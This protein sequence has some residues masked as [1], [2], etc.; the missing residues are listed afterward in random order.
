MPTAN[1]ASIAT[2]AVVAVCALI[3]VGPAVWGFIDGVVVFPWE[4]NTTTTIIVPP[5]GQVDLFMNLNHFVDGGAPAATTVWLYDAN[6]NFFSSAASSTNLVTFTQ[7]ATPGAHLWYQIRAAAPNAAAYATYTSPLREVIV[8]EGDVNGDAFLTLAPVMIHET[9]TSAATFTITDQIGQSINAEATQYVNA[10]D[11][12]LFVN[13]GVTSDCSWGTPEDFI[14]ARTGRHYLW[15]GWVV[16]SCTTSQ[17]ITNADF[18]FSTPTLYY[19]G[20]RLPT[21]TNFASTGYNTHILAIMAPSGF[22]ASADFD[23]D[24]YDTMW[25]SSLTGVTLG[26]FLNGDSDLNPT[27]LANKVV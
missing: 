13:I 27:A 25:A 5:G 8:P 16:L 19:Y 4:K 12:S 14:D 10:T 22:T 23:F 2:L 18:A 9:S 11:T 20:F 6:M 17:G 15:G 1:K 7:K 26:S 24:L 3:L 21:I